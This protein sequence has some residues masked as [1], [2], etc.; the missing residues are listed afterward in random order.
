LHWVQTGRLSI[1]GVS[2]L[3]EIIIFIHHEW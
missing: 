2:F 1:R 3:P